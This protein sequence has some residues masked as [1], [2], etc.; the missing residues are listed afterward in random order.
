MAV[1]D[2]GRIGSCA[3]SLDFQSQGGPRHLPDA[4][5]PELPDLPGISGSFSCGVRYRG[6]KIALQ[7]AVKWAVRVKGDGAVDGDQRHVRGWSV[8]VAAILILTG[9][10]AALVWYFFGVGGGDD[11]DRSVTATMTIHE[12]SPRNDGTVHM[13]YEWELKG[14]YVTVALARI[15]GGSRFVYAKSR[16]GGWVE[17]SLM[18]GV[19]KG[20]LAEGSFE[21]GECIES[22]MVAVPARIDLKRGERFVIV[23]CQKKTGPPVEL[24]VYC[25]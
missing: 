16:K 4:E 3:W 1:G 19:V 8:I 11:V 24:I 23:T 25:E 22:E 6:R 12:L 9:T 20:G 18:Q 17:E 5:L 15:S 7:D 21:L 14:H 10:A 2:S 13:R